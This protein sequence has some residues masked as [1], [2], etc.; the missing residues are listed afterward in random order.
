ML[1]RKAAAIFAVFFGLVSLAGVSHAAQPEVYTGRF[2]KLAVDGYD[3]VA[4]FVSGA[5]VKGS[6]EF[7][8]DYKGATWKFASAENLEKFKADPAAYAPQFGGYCAWAVAHGYTARGNP[9]FWAVVDGKL[10]LNYDGGVQKQW[11]E[12]VPGFIAQANANWPDV[13]KK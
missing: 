12:D 2:S 6:S 7:S 10:Y 5:P 11:Q 1:A 9:N 8:L 13:L 3:P 4:Y